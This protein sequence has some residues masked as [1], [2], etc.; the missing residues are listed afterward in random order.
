MKKSI[1][2]LSCLLG[3]ALTSAYSQDIYTKTYKTE[4]NI[5]NATGWSYWFI[6]TGGIA[7]TLNVKMSSVTT[8][9][10][11]H[12]PH[13]HPHD[14]FF[15]LLEGEAYMQFGEERQ[16]LHV[17][18]GFYA[19]GSASHAITRLDA[20]GPITY[21][22]FNREP[23]GG[24]KTPFPFWK[25]TYTAEDCYIPY[26]ERKNFWYVTPEMTLNGFNV[27]S[28]YIKGNKVNKTKADGRYLV[29]VVMEGSADITV[30]NESVTLSAMSV[31]YVPAGTA[32]TV[33][34]TKGSVPLRYLSA[35][36][37]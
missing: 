16:T 21:L 18:D 34:R 25:E 20:D 11:P 17:G 5:P 22:M 26:Q 24:V 3:L 12:T 1:A 23:K 10:A 29:Y 2:L 27:R 30:G 14:E 35:R 31:C 37:H 8:G 15:I 36:I 9:T 33:R 7:D 13:R 28:N 6:P 4:D 19:P 32:S